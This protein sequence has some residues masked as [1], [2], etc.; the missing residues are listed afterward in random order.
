MSE[1]ITHNAEQTEQIGADLGS[2][3]KPGDFI[4]LFGTMG[5]EK[6]TFINGV[7]RGMGIVDAVSSPTFALIHEYAGNIPLYHFDMYRINSWDDLYSTGYFDYCESKG[8]I[9]VEWSENIEMALP[10]E[11]I[12]VELFAGQGFEERRI[13]ITEGNKFENTCC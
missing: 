9:A 4:A 5:T 3:L 2:R 13:L 10:P 11:F 7:A 6:T 8:V 1:H 12:K